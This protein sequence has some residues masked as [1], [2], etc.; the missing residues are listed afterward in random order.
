MF[1]LARSEWSIENKLHFILDVSF[2]KDANRLRNG[3][4]GESLATIR[5]L[6]LNI[7]KQENST[8]KS[9]KT[10]RLKCGWDNEY[11]FNIL[12]GSKKENQ[13]F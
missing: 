1:E 8:K 7:I 10:K 13:L 11:L 4:A 9:V 12:L 2:N 5:Q 3:F 6:C